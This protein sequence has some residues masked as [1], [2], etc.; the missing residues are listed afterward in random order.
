MDR[1]QLLVGGAGVGLHG[2]GQVGVVPPVAR[3]VVVEDDQRLGVGLGQAA[4]DAFGGFL[5]LGREWREQRSEDRDG[6]DENSS[7][8]RHGV[9]LLPAW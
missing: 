8:K 2:H 1:R 6:D 4:G 9:V 7:A 5:R 3:V